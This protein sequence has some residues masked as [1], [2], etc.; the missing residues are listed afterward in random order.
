[1]NNLQ[2]DDFAKVLH[3]PLNPE[4][5]DDIV[6]YADD[7][8]I[9]SYK[10]NEDLGKLPIINIYFPEEL[11][12][13][14]LQEP[15]YIQYLPYGSREINANLSN[16]DLN[17]QLRIDSEVAYY[18]SKHTLM[19]FKFMNGK[20][21]G[22]A[23]AIYVTYKNKMY[24]ISAGHTFRERIDEDLYVYLKKDSY[25]HLNKCH[26]AVFIPNNENDFK[27]LDLML[28]EISSEDKILL[29]QNDYFPFDLGEEPPFYDVYGKYNICY[30]FPAS[31][32][33]PSNYSKWQTARSLCLDLPF[34]HELLK[35]EGI[36]DINNTFNEIDFRYS[37]VLPYK[38]RVTYT[39][40][41]KTEQTNLV[42][43]LNGMSGCG[44][45]YFKNYPY[46]TK[47]YSLI[48]IFMGISKN[49]KYIY[50]DKIKP[51]LE[52]F[53]KVL[54]Y[55]KKEKGIDYYSTGNEQVYN[56]RI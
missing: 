28:L 6:F 27:A 11:K 52:A 34:E 23:S 5:T 4:I 37:S 12:E 36:V 2:N 8:R 39:K 45:W 54:E 9:D 7:S 46:C 19:I 18:A 26:G 44:V 48:G 25:I 13:Y 16:F 30:G 55:F 42:A 41:I 51:I 3:K 14:L 50:M 47:P 32:N 24:F 22:I 10:L 53:N 29:E 43:E 1:M 35:K 33:K 31:Y 38:R 15:H 17:I 49:K 56:R 20:P 21:E 40:V